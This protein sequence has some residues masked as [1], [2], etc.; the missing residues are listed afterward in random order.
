MIREVLLFALLFAGSADSHRR[1]SLA[2]LLRLG[3]LDFAIVDFLFDFLL[4]GLPLELGLGLTGRLFV[5]DDQS[6]AHLEGVEV[7]NQVLAAVQFFLV[8]VR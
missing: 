2:L 6:C 7:A 3:D 4:N 8:G 1:R 5:I